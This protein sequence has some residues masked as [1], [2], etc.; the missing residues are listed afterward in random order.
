MRELVEQLLAAKRPK[1]ALGAARLQIEKLDSPLIVRLL[2]DVATTSS[3]HDSNIR[4]QGYEFSRAFEI[5]DDRADVSADELAH[6]EFLYLSA[7]QHEKRGIPNLERQ[8]AENPGLFAQAVGLSYRRK[9]PGEDPA[10]WQI[11]NEEARASAGTLAYW[12]L[13][14]AKRIPGTGNDGKI[15]A[16][17]LKAWL[18][19]ARALCKTYGRELAGDNSIGELLSKSGCD[20][21]GLWPAA[22]VRDALEEFGNQAIAEGM[23]VGLYNQRG[24]HWRDIGGKQER[25]LAS[26]YRGWSKQTALEWPFSSRLLERIAQ[27]YDRDAEWHDTNA[28]LLKRLPY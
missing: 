10:E 19:E 25:E 27:S 8:L 20:E 2:K 24:A 1:A 13:H 22:A 7:L 4:F 17:K 23:A 16:A 14:R 28:N 15:D 26:M 21:D 9:D 18:R 11:S 12:L 3:E 6:L 5:L